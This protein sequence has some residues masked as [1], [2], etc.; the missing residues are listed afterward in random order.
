MDRKPAE[1]GDRAGHGE[2]ERAA[3][4]SAPMPMV[5]SNAPSSRPSNAPSRAL[6]PPKR[7]MTEAQD[8]N[9]IKAHTYRTDTA[10]LLTA[11]TKAE[12]KL[13]PAPAV[14][15]PV[16]ARAACPSAPRLP[17]K[18]RPTSRDAN[19]CTPQSAAPSPAS[20]Q[21]AAPTAPMRNAGP[22][23]L[24]NASRRSACPF[25]PSVG[26]QAAGDPRAHG[27]P[28]TLRS[29]APQTP[30]EAARRSSRMTPER[31]AAAGRESR[32][33]ADLG[34]DHEQEEG[35]ARCFSR[36][37]VTLRRTASA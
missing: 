30:R 12:G 35:G 6:N 22:Q 3:P 11:A 10:L 1:P 14:A 5:I 36:Q 4:G 8:M 2:R 31:A 25:Q 33:H 9:T 28:A 17:R 16:P 26:V 23:L 37:P 27:K 19:I 32:T 29:P 13:R 15:R 20:P 24:Q 21:I 18:S 7:R 34:R